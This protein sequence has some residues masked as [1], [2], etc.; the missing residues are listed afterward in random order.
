LHC[1]G[2]LK[3]RVKKGVEV[4]L[5]KPSKLTLGYGD[6]MIAR[7]AWTGFNLNLMH[8][9]KIILNGDSQI[10]FGSA[11]SID[12]NG[13]FEIGDQSYISAGATIRVAQRIS[14]GN[15]C[16]ISWNVTIMD[17]DFHRYQQADGT[18]S[19]STREVI[20]GNNVWIGNNVII[21][22]GVHIGNNAIIAAGSVVTKDVP[23]S[24]I[25]GGNP[26]QTIKANITPINPGFN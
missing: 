7:F 22:K 17:S 6:G 18:L 13:I 16:A 3:A 5:N 8:N 4:H 15:Y 11:L 19:K 24:T 10:G 14:I 20:I 23:P 12:K 1:K 26:A 9:A 25:V 21:L 2:L